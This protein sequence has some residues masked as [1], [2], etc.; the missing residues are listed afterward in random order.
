M[1]KK[2]RILHIL[3]IAV[4]L[5]SFSVVYLSITGTF[6][7]GQIYVDV[8][9]KQPTNNIKGIEGDPIA[10]VYTTD[11]TYGNNIYLTNQFPISDE[12]GKN[13]EGKY[14]TFDFELEF[15][16]KSIGI[17]YEITLEKMS[18]SNLADDWIKVYLEEEG[19]GL[20]N[21]Y[22]S[23]GRIKTYSDY[24]KYKGKNNEIVLYKGTVSDKNIN[25]KYRSFR[26]RMWVSEDVNINDGN[27]MNK[28]FIAR[29]NV[30]ATGS[31]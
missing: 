14:K 27:Y 19:K 5:I 2:S 13:L 1:K 4:I 30:H 9:P 6:L 26:F 10:Y 24:A 29:V 17:N 12:V 8:I 20:S 18:G 16:E 15:N 22:R 3:A 11:K 25:G 7:T 23:N 21:C 28:S 31:L